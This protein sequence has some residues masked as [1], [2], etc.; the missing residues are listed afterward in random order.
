[1][2]NR[3]LILFLLTSF[4]SCGP[5]VAISSKQLKYNSSLAS[6]E[7]KTPNETGTLKRGKPDTITTSTATYPVSIYSSYLALEFIAAKPLT[8]K[9]PVK[10]KGTVKKNELVL[11]V[12]KA[13]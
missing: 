12:I 3:L 13:Q 4:I 9:M 6:E 11:E 2:D 1:M 7:E 5:Q 8:T 10:F